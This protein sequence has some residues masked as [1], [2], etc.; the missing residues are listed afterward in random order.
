MS[1]RAP[2]ST[3]WHVSAPEPCAPAHAAQ[4]AASSAPTLQL[5][6]RFLCCIPLQRCLCGRS[7]MMPC[8]AAVLP[9]THADKGYRC[10]RPGQT[11]P[12]ASPSQ[13]APS[14]ARQAPQLPDAA[15]AKPCTLPLAASAVGWQHCLLVCPDTDGHGSSVWQ[16]EPCCSLLQKGRRAGTRHDHGW[17]RDDC[18]QHGHLRYAADHCC[19]PA[20]ACRQAAYRTSEFVGNAASKGACT[21]C[22]S[23]LH[24]GFGAHQH[25]CIHDLI[26]CDVSSLLQHR[27]V[28]GL[29]DSAQS[30]VRHVCAACSVQPEP[31]S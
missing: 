6:T 9:R 4:H 21:C 30:H 27:P 8:V 28:V 2:S 12:R 18:H 11:S 25:G 20:A 24:S 23:R 3:C 29:S 10:R 15:Q 31:G 16:H 26:C 19:L 22:R 7:R 1:R 14:S 13:M 17:L 5:P